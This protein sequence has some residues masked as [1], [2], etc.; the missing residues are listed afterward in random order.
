MVFLKGPVYTKP[1]KAD[2]KL[3]R[4]LLN[5][6]KYNLASDIRYCVTWYN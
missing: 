2:L 1:N 6:N 4:N 5:R 3:A